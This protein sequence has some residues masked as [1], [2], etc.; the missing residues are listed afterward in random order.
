MKRKAYW[1]S[2]GATL[3]SLQKV[4]NTY[5]KLQSPT[6]KIASIRD[7]KRICDWMYQDATIFLKRKKVIIDECLKIPKP[8]SGH[9][10]IDSNY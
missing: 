1:F 2:N 6:N 9:R 4:L 10:F 7:C 5:K 3:M 8:G